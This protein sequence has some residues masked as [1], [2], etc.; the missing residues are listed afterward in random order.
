MDVSVSK[1]ADDLVVNQL[2]ESE[3]RF[4]L[5]CEGALDA[6]VSMDDSDESQV[7]IVPPKACSVIWLKT[8]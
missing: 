6:I 7:G 3:E 2:R 4:R 5:I 1:H 8:Q